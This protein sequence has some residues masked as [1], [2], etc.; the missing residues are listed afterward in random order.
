MTNVVPFFLDVLGGGVLPVVW[1]FLRFLPQ[2]FVLFC[3]LELFR[4]FRFV[5]TSPLLAFLLGF[6]CTTLAVC[7]LSERGGKKVLALCFVPC[8]ARLP[9]MLLI[10]N[11]LGFGIWLPLALYLMSGM[12][13]YTVWRLVCKSKTPPHRTCANCLGKNPRYFTRVLTQTLGFLR[14][15]SLPVLMFSVILYILGDALNTIGG[16]VAPTLIPIGLASGA[17]VVVIVFGMLGKEMMAATLV[18]LGVTFATTASALSF[19]VFATLM[20]PCF[21][22]ISA[23]RA[24]CGTRLALVCVGFGLVVAYAAAFVVHTVVVLY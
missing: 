1:T 13:A 11:M 16:M 17:V 5:R 18:T 8:S 19:V 2:V 21:A 10:A 14:R 23:I 24:R 7:A 9:V 4:N 22:A 6:A 15:I 20:P 3:V 12:V